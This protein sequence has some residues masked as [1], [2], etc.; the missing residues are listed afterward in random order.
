[1]RIAVGQASAYDL[2]LS[3]NLKNAKL[4]RAPTSPAVVDL[5]V[6]QKLEVLSGL[7]PR[8]VSDAERL[9]GSRLLEGQF[10]AIQ[11]A[12]GTPKGRAAA[13]GYL[14]EFAED[15]KASGFVAQAIA[16]NA[17]RG[18]SVAPRAAA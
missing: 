5:F 4:V 6:A 8:L 17:V 14:R 3:R 15:V 1:M 11:Q 2:F 10:T 16:R 12:L 7:K 18:V 13:A 9:P